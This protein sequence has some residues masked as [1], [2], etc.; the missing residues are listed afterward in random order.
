MRRRRNADIHPAK[1]SYFRFAVR[2]KVAPLLCDP[3]VCF[4]EL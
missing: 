1:L 4:A 2:T 3:N